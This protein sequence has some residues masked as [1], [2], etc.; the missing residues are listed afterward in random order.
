MSFLREAL[1]WVLLILLVGRLFWKRYKKR[2]KAL[3]EKQ[4][5]KRPW[6]L[7][8]K[9]PDDCPACVEGE[10]LR[11]VNAEPR[12]LPPPWK[13]CKGPGGPRKRIDTEGH[14]CINPECRYFRIRD[15]HWHA[16]VGNGVRGETDDIQRL[17]CQ[18]CKRRFTVRCNTVLRNL[19]NSTG[20]D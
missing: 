12:A 20:A 13:T 17:I 1:P 7:N 19:K 6:S 3:F 9:T 15:A 8:P 10:T 5:T 4:K 14:C 16:L 18:A 11:K 2:I